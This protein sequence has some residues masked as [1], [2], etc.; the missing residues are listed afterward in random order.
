[1]SLASSLWT[2]PGGYKGGLRPIEARDFRLKKGNVK[3]KETGEKLEVIG[4]R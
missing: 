4:E 1:M 3:G 2:A